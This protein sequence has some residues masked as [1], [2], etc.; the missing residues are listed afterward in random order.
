MSIFIII[1]YIIRLSFATITTKTTPM[2]ETTTTSTAKSNDGGGSGGDDA[3]FNNGT[4]RYD[5][6]EKIK[7]HERIELVLINYSLLIVIFGVVLN[8]VNFACFYRM[9]KR[10]AQN[11]YLGALSAAEALNIIINIGVPLFI[12]IF[13]RGWLGHALK[14]L[15]HKR[16]IGFYCI[17][18]SYLVEVR[19]RES[20]F[21]LYIY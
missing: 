19:E 12:L 6:E 9:K 14:D 4:L 8:M 15:L 10:N 13:N 5:Y 20:S 11:L 2:T 3:F 18:Y 21:Y 17:M 7:L 16:F 1:S